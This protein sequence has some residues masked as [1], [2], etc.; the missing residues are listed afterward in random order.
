MTKC[1][2]KIPG[3]FIRLNKKKEIDYTKALDAFKRLL[4]LEEKELYL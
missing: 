2:K 4:S 3:I 1:Q